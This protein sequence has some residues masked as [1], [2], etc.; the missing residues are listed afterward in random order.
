MSNFS[1]ILSANPDYF[2]Q[3]RA[4]NIRE[5]WEG[6]K[7]IPEAS[8]PPAPIS[9]PAS[10]QHAHPTPPLPP[11]FFITY[12][13]QICWTKSIAGFSFFILGIANSP[14]VKIGFFSLFCFVSSA[15]FNTVNEDSEETLIYGLT[16]DYFLT[17][18]VIVLIVENLE[19]N[20]YFFKKRKDNT[21]YAETQK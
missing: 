1:Y 14:G 8:S 16:T 10:S 4:S 18:E 6:Q 17:T 2:F 9:F 20:T 19:I 15:I 21:S 11:P 13:V 7:S 3:S 5:L 12:L